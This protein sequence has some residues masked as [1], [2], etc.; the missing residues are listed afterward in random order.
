MPGGPAAQ[1]GTR[2]D[3]DDEDDEEREEDDGKGECEEGCGEEEGEKPLGD[4]GTDGDGVRDMRPPPA[5]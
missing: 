5:V 2:T 1:D 4:T 3:E